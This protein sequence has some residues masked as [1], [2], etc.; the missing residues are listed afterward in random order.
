MLVIIILLYCACAF[1]FI[2]NFIA[3][4][5]IGNA[6][7]N[8]G[9]DKDGDKDDN[10]NDDG[11]DKDGNDNKMGWI[12]AA[13]CIGAAGHA[14][15]GR[16]SPTRPAVAPAAAAPVDVDQLAADFA[17]AKI[18]LLSFNFQLRYPHIFIPTLPLT[19]GQAT[20]VGYWL[21]PFMNQTR[22]SV[23]VSP[24]GTHSIF[25]MNI[26]RQFTDLNLHVFLEVNQ[27]V[28]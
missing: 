6:N 4:E 28:D 11:K 20:V 14:S 19:S 2:L 27:V 23:E 12:P 10:D 17:H 25:L 21:V 24:K 9:D 16:S 15:H 22:F 7:K 18:D 1:T 5:G 13:S 26:P 3:E 8:K